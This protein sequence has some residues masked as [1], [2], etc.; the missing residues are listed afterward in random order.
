MTAQIRKITARTVGIPSNLDGVG[1]AFTVYGRVA[2]A[3]GEAGEL[4]D[5]VRLKGTFECV[6][7]QTG[8]YFRAPV[9]IA[10]GGLL[11]NELMTALHDAQD[12]DK[13]AVVDMAAR[14]YLAESDNAMGREWRA[15]SLLGPAQ[16]D[17]VKRLHDQIAGKLS[18]PAPEKTDT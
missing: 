9:F 10:P 4:G 13:S 8:E 5:Y 7:E 15:E 12:N 18:L 16:D 11:E 2:S 3:K 6:N 1:C 17:P 14:F